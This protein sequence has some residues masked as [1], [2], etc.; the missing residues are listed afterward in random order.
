M[1]EIGMLYQT[2]E[3]A[4]S[5]ADENNIARVRTIT[6][7]V[8]ECAGVFPEI[9]T[10]YFPYVAEQYPKLKDARIQIKMVPSECLCTECHSLYNV[11]KNEGE[12]P[13]CHSHNKK[14]LG[15]TEVKLLNI[16]Y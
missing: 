13:R 8:G 1:H 12:C 2:A 11:L 15:G 9:F 7:E 16:G 5:F 4:V 3:T 10:N 6:L 14:V